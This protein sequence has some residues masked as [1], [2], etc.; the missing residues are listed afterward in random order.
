M[1]CKST[2]FVPTVQPRTCSTR[3][4]TASLRRP[5]GVVAVVGI[6]RVAQRDD[7]WLTVATLERPEHRAVQVA[8][9]FRAVKV[10]AERTGDDRAA[11]VGHHTDA[12]KRV[13]DARQTREEIAVGPGNVVGAVLAV[14]GGIRREQRGEACGVAL[15]VRLPELL[16]EGARLLRRR[17]R[18]SAER[19]G[20]GGEGRGIR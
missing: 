2:T 12:G 11:A 13:G 19:R 15:L 8:V 9:A 16:D 18:R 14:A 17:S 10:H 3:S 6:E 1:R 5:G 7:A 20:E 4:A